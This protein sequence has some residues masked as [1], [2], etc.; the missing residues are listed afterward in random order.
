MANN[1]KLK[2]II[3][4]LQ[5]LSNL[6]NDMIDSEIY[7]VS[8]FSQAFDLIQKLQSDIHTL[9]ADQVEL[10]ASQMKKH[11][12]LILSIHQQMRNITPDISDQKPVSAAKVAKPE[13]INDDQKTI[14]ETT[15]KQPEVKVHGQNKEKPK[16]TSLFSRLGLY[17][18]NKENSDKTEIIA[19]NANNDGRLIKKQDKTKTE[20]PGPGIETKKP[21]QAI[22]EN[23][24][25][26]PAKNSIVDKPDKESDREKSEI[27]IPEK[28]DFPS[29]IKTHSNPPAK[30][31][32][33]PQMTR[34]GSTSEKTDTTT[35]PPAAAK[36][37]KTAPLATTMPDA[38]VTHNTTV[39]PPTVNT[40]NDI[41]ITKNAN[42]PQSVNDAIE[43]K[44]LSDL[45]KAFSLNDRFR[46]RKELFGGNEETMNKVITIL[47]SK[48]SFKE[49]V[50]FLE[51]KLHWDF[52]NPIVKD[53]IKV[54]ELRFL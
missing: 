30:E 2:Q 24:I 31:V 15:I 4:N 8:F 33:R 3:S 49:S 6:M 45:R 39:T 32:T 18:D 35:N 38:T 27:R 11:Q 51:E 7:P 12:A 9:E 52:S 40:A 22:I 13:L 14:I 50:V 19:K 46:Y 17:K 53:F 5:I 36:L 10:F 1:D 26:I 23:P 28:S 41:F 54:L 47:N 34:P 43:K 44:K 20:A 16:K 37:Q 48:V 29:T 25:N 42:T 21:T